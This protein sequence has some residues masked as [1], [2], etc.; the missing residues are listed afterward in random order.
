MAHPKKF[1]SDVTVAGVTGG[2]T[3]DESVPRAWIVLSEEGK[4]LG[5]SA[6]VKELEAWHQSNLSRYKWLRGGIEVINEVSAD[7]VSV[8]DTTEVRDRFPNHL[9]GR[10]LG[11]YFKTNMRNQSRASLSCDDWWHF[12]RTPSAKLGDP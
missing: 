5:A 8:I 1:I 4:K 6:V 10:H 11:G 7:S 2:R 12:L 9:A 3:S